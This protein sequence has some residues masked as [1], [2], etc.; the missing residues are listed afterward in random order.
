MNK[1]ADEKMTVQN[2][3]WVPRSVAVDDAEGIPNPGTRSASSPRVC[4]TAAKTLL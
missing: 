1:N 2:W 4:L 3:P